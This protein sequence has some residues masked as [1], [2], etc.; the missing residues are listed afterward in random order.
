MTLN[1]RDTKQ[2]LKLKSG[3]L[4]IPHELKMVFWAF[5]RGDKPILEFERY[6]YASEPIFLLL[7]AQSYEHL[8]V[9]VST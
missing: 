7:T 9:L 2:V 5:V 8:I 3:C 4:D 6:I 1:Q